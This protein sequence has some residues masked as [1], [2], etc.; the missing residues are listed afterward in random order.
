M[1]AIYIG[2]W[3]VLWSDPIRVLQSF[4][5]YKSIGVSSSSQI[6]LYSLYYLLFG[7]PVVTLLYFIAGSITGLWRLKGKQKQAFYLVLFWLIVSLGRVFLPQI[8]IYGGIRQVIEYVPALA[9]LA[10]IGA[11]QIVLIVPKRI[12]SFKV[13]SVATIAKVLIIFFFIPISLKLIS[14]HQDY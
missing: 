6:K 8:N 4:S 7:T 10:G 11:S 14:I 13:I 9:I 5:F 1:L 12:S 2:S 3:P